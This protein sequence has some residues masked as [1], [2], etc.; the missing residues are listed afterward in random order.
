M[1]LGYSF[2]TSSSNRVLVQR[3]IDKRVPNSKKNS[4]MR[5]NKIG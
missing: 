4:L 3:L 2:K 1:L 5:E